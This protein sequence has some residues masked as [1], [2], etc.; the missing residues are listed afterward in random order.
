MQ[1]N[2]VHVFVFAVLTIVVSRQA[3][4]QPPDVEDDY[5]KEFVWGIN[6]NT[7]GGLIGGFFLR[8]SRQKKG[9]LYETFGLELLNVKHP[10]EERYPSLQTGAS[11]IWG[12][13][14]YLYSVR[15][16]YGYDKIIYRKAPQ[17]GVQINAGVAGGPTLGIVSPYYV[18]T[19]GG[20]YRK[21]DPDEIST[22]REINGPGRIFQGL[23]ESSIV[24]G[25]NAR[26][27][28]SFEFGAFRNNVTGIEI[29]ASAEQFFRKIILVPTQEN[30]SFYTA[31]FITLFWGTRK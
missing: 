28:V 21:Y 18:L 12:K 22:L 20:Q 30:R 13:Q 27:S 6:K 9:N 31:A 17:Q 23:G 10:D 29:G 25:L 8:H 1:K 14:N 5:F 24:P 15:L 4:A 7:N 26:A 2:L 19:Q 11:F 3:Y 16:H